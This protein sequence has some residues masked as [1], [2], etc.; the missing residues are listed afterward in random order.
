[1]EAGRVRR[2]KDRA[3]TMLNEFSNQSALQLNIRTKIEELVSSCLSRTSG[4]L[5]QRIGTQ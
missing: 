3:N 2:V 1:M 5:R 4:E